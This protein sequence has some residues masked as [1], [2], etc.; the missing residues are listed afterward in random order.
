MS[1]NSVFD[2]L[3]GDYL[4]VIGATLGRAGRPLTLG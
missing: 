3:F 1:W 2:L 4:T